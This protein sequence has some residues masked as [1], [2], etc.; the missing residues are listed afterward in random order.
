MRGFL[1]GHLASLEQIRILGGLSLAALISATFF[2]AMHLVLLFSGAD[3]ATVVIV[4]C[5]TFSLGLLAAHQRSRTGS[6]APAI[7]V[8]MAGNVGGFLVGI[9]FAIITIITTGKPPVG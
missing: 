8:H 1:Q 2:G 3:L 6:L 9:I 5:F 7:V 4:L